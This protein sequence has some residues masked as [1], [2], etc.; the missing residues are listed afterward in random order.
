MVINGKWRVEKNHQVEAGAYSTGGGSFPAAINVTTVANSGLTISDLFARGM[1]A[2]GPSYWHYSADKDNCQKFIWDTLSASG[3]IT[4][5][6]S[7]SLHS[8]IIQDPLKLLEGVSETRKTL[9]NIF[10]SIANI[11]QQAL[12]HLA[13]QYIGSSK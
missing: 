8:F 9:L 7:S 5:A 13:Q 2:V 4:P 6:N 3:L 1:Q 10:P 11:S 12:Y